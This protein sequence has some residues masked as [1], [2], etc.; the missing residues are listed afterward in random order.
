MFVSHNPINGICHCP[1]G[2][3]KA[4]AT[5]VLQK[6]LPGA[7]HIFPETTWATGPAGK[8]LQTHKHCLK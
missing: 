6:G 8:P 5:Q 1:E 7:S 2:T 3:V 4:C